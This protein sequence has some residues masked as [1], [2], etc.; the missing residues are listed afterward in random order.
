MNKLGGARLSRRPPLGGGIREPLARLEH[1]SRLAR[2]EQARRARAEPLGRAHAQLLLEGDDR[3][4]HA[5]GAACDHV[6]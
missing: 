6:W 5:P 4:A 2:L 1:R 3:A